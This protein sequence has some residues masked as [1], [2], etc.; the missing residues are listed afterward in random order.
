MSEAKISFLIVD[1]DA[2]I[3]S[4]LSYILSEFGHSVR[5]AADGFTALSEIRAGLPDIIITDLNMPGMSGFE[6]IS[7]IRRRFPAIQMIAMTGE[8]PGDGSEPGL[9][10]DAFYEKGSSLISLFQIVENMAHPS[11]LPAF[12]HPGT[13]A[14]IW[15][16]ND[17]QN[18]SE[19]G[20]AIITCPECQKTFP[21][22]LGETIDPVHET[23]CLYCHRLIHYSVAHPA[24][25]T[26]PKK[27]E[28]KRHTDS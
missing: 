15:I 5:S 12:R 3:R 19:E 2:S 22:P 23:T 4:S 14:S 26:S 11:L 20:Y 24:E 17:A 8:F 28:A 1:D 10:A 27:I 7:L 21:I 25:P 16:P 6:F 18:L 13:S 9:A